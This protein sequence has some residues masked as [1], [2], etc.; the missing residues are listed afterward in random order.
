MARYSLMFRKGLRS[1]H[2]T[3]VAFS[4]SWSSKPVRSSDECQDP[5]GIWTLNAIY[6]LLMRSVAAAQLPEMV[7]PPST[8]N[9]PEKSQK[10]V[11]NQ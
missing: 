4:I 9:S 11:V 6:G 2:G 1:D 3:S 5:S 7:A 10:A 8:G